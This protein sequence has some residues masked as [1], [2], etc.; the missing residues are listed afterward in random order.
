MIA[1]TAQAS[2]ADVEN[3]HQ[4]LSEA[5]SHFDRGDLDGARQ[6]CEKLLQNYPDYASAMSL[7]AVIHMQQAS[8]TGAFPYLVKASILS[9]HDPSIFADLG[10][11]YLELGAGECALRSLERAKILDQNE[12]MAYFFMGEVMLQ[13]EDY[14]R[15]A[16]YFRKLLD[17]QPDHSRGKV[18]LVV[19]QAKMNRIDDDVSTLKSAFEMTLAREEKALLL[20]VLAELRVPPEDIDILAAVNELG[21]PHPDDTELTGHLINFARGILL[22]KKG[23]FQ[24]AWNCLNQANRQIAEANTTQRRTYFKQGQ[25]LLDKAINWQP[26][27]KASASHSGDKPVS[28]FILGPSRSGKI[29]L[30]SLIGSVE[31]VRTGRE[32]NIVRD[33]ALR[34]AQ[35]SDLLSE[36]WLANLP[37]ELNDLFSEIYHG[38]LSRYGADAR[39]LTITHPGSIFDVGRLV[40]C[41]PEARFIFMKRDLDDTAFRIFANFYS[42]NTNQFSNNINDIYEYLDLHNSLIDNWMD[43]LGSKTMTVSYEDLVENPQSTLTRVC[44]FCGLKPSSNPDLQIEDDRGCAEPYRKWLHDAHKKNA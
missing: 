23:N 12:P 9:S 21:D 38:V 42:L 19:C 32:D 37:V 8:Y 33:T 20:F 15:A 44:K 26:A 27:K 43:R 29:S 5:K 39:L 14:V 11:I 7:L 28:L 30:E 34:T 24:E 4:R 2:I 1:T 41:V 17:V 36:E 6:L 13:R 22:D 40:D 31:G 3:A 35:K 16:E 10:K 25:A 18:R